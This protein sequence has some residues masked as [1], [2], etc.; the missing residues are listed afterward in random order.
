[1]SRRSLRLEA[2]L[3]DRSLPH[4]SASF[5]AGAASWRNASSRSLRSRGSQQLSTSCS[6]SLL[7]PRTPL[8]SAGPSLLNS[9]VASDASLISSLLEESTIQ[10]STLVDTLWESAAA[11]EESSAALKPPLSRLYCTN[12]EA[13]CSSCA[14]A[15][16]QTELGEEEAS[17]VYRGGRSRRRRENV[18]QVVGD[19][20]A[21]CFELLLHTCQ[22]LVGSK[23]TQED[24]RAARPAPPGV[25]SL[26]EAPAQT[27]EVQPAG[28]LC[29]DC[30]EAQRSGSDAASSSSSSSSSVLSLLRSSAAFTAWTLSLLAHTAAAVLWPVISE[31]LRAAWSSGRSAGGLLAGVLGP[32]CRRWRRSCSSLIRSPLGLL[33]LFLLLLLLGVT[34]FGPPALQ[35]VLVS[36]WTTALSG[37]Y[38][39]ESSESQSGEE[40]MRPQEEAPP[41]GAAE[42]GVEEEE[43]AVSAAASVEWARVSRV[44]QRLAALWERVEAGGRRAERRHD[45]VLRLH[46][47]LQRQR[48]G[49]GAWLN[50][51]LDRQLSE[52]RRRLD[53]DRQQREQVR[54]A[55]LLQQDAHTARLDQLELQLKALTAKTQEV[56][57]NHEVATSAPESASTLPAAVS[58]G[59]DRRSHDALAAEVARLEAALRDVRRD[60]DGLSGCGSGCRQLATA[61]QD[62]S[63]QI[64]AQVRAEL[65]ALEW[66]AGG[67]EALLQRLSQRCVSHAHLQEALSALQRRVLH[68]A[69][70]QPDQQCSDGSLSDSAGSSVTAEDVHQMVADALRLFSEDRTGMADYALESGG[71]SILSTRCSETYETKAALLSLFGVPLWYFSQSPRVVIQPDVHPGNCWAFRGSSG[72]L[73]I[74]LS[75]R[76]RPTAVTLEHISRALAPSRQLLSAPRDFSVYG[77]DHESEERGTLLGTFS[78][79]Q[80]GDAL[81]T[82]LVTDD[83]Q[84]TFQIVEVQVLSNWGH[85][86]YTCLYRIRVHGTPAA[87]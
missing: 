73:V 16:G 47:A 19:A 39:P 34:W 41:L 8:K 13:S 79:D 55:D 84:K 81:Q 11:V 59:A 60:V 66:G 50:Q 58:V 51:L 53:R 65:Q 42:T 52:I 45:E 5:S 28:S 83:S 33:L 23:V 46:A 68:G 26:K 2:S 22:V 71:G 12:C 30:Q 24:R 14:A 80:D 29:D 74:R 35:S 44:E 76:I 36:D 72:F 7:L 82:F 75:M 61:Q 49:E 4:S 18:L 70:P 31:T 20:T 87:A 78:Y 48:D 43:A 64:A 62:I 63:G 86:D 32:P 25:M 77:L 1:M 69:G 67:G 40:A 15:S 57:W 3:L 54:Q 37:V 21:R 17:T 56:H 27:K 6:E 10:E 9:S 85:P 38:H